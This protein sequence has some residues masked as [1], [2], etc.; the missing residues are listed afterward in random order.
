MSAIKV[1]GT[2]LGAALGGVSGIALL[3]KKKKTKTNLGNDEWVSVL[4]NEA[5]IFIP[6]GTADANDV[7][8]DCSVPAS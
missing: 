4:T 7:H 6:I 3:T 1:Y 5:F 8:R 2:L